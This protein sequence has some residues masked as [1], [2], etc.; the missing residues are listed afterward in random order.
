M[1]IETKTSFARSSG[2][3]SNREENINDDRG[4]DGVNKPKPQFRDECFR[5]MDLM[6]ELLVLTFIFV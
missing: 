5:K 2:S 4:P 6:I 3:S 1:S